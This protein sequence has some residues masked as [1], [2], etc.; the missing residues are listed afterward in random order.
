[1]Q[2]VCAALYLLFL[3]STFNAHAASAQSSLRAGRPEI[4]RV[5]FI[6]AALGVATQLGDRLKLQPPE[7]RHYL[8]LRHQVGDSWDY[9]VIENLGTEVTLNAAD[10][11]HP[12]ESHELKEWQEEAV[13][14][15]PPWP[16]FARAM[17]IDQLIARTAGSIYN[18]S[19]YHAALGHR[20]QLE[21]MLSAPPQE[22]NTAAGNVLLDRMEGGSW[23]YVDVVR[24]NS[25]QDFGTNGSNGA[26]Q[27]RKGGGGWSQVRD[28]ANLHRD[29]LADRIAP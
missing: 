29:T 3:V 28:H 25:W 27:L 4:Y 5:R 1:M 9:A 23:D 2:P 11:P 8:V 26:A 20:R 22:G 18:I 6:K 17:G 19:V 7:V 15:G 12:A 13:L 14:S 16:E 21:E 10:A 24:Y